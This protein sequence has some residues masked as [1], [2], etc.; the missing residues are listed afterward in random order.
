MIKDV[1]H[2]CTETNMLIAIWVFNSIFYILFVSHLKGQSHGL[3]TFWSNS[4]S[5]QTKPHSN[6]RKK[7]LVTE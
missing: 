3:P 2:E 1:K 7:P 4:R 5:F 6:S